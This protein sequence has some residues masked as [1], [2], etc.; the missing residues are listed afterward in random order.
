MFIS[1]YYFEL[2]RKDITPTKS[3]EEA[4]KT[5]DFDGIGRHLAIQVAE[6]VPQQIGIILSYLA[7]YPNMG[8]AG[9]GMLETTQSLKEARKQ[10]KDP[11][12]SAYNSLTKGIIEAGFE[13][14]GTMGILKKWGST[15]TKSFGTKNAGQIIVDV[16]KTIFW[17]ILGEGNE[18]WWTS[19]G[20]DFSDFVT[21][22]NKDAMKGSL[23]RA[24]EAGVVGGISGG[25]L[26]G[27]GAIR[28]GYSSASLNKMKANGEQVRS[29]TLYQLLR[30]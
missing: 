14:I 3:F 13:S 23:V 19:L 15:L 30:I 26:T 24:F 27:P 18:E 2:Y 21:G 5:K 17:S 11:A 25:L 8:L 10:K 7:G 6:N 20:Q 16:F 12:M 4:F 22:I 1:F 9:M 28:L 29:R